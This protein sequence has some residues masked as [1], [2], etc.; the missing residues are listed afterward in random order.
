M[1]A[2]HHSEKLRRAGVEIP[3]WCIPPSEVLVSEFEREFCVT[4]PADYRAFLL[5][6]GGCALNASVPFQEPTPVGD[7]AA[8]NY[9]FGFMPADRSSKDVRWNTRLIEGAP[10]IVAIA[11]DLMGGMMWLRCTGDATGAVYYH[12]GEQRSTWPDSTFRARFA[13]LHP[14]LEAFL[15]LRRNGG[16]RTKPKGYE[17]VYLI[18]RSF[19]EFLDA[20]EAETEEEQ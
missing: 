16:L 1:L 17:N 9:F 2:R 7:S 12:D 20:L 8:V 5:E 13:S 14:S 15:A 18:A 19:S 10:D 4:L 3:K 11:G 6:H